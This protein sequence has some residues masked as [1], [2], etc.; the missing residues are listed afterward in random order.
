[1]GSPVIVWK[2]AAYSTV[3]KATSAALNLTTGGL[4]PETDA[5]FYVLRKHFGASLPK[6]KEFV[7]SDGRSYVIE[8]VETSACGAYLVLRCNEAGKRV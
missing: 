1:M 2:G 4:S 8:R 3:P 6:A 5:A 7:V